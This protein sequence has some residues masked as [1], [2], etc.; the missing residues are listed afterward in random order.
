MTRAA[1]GV[2]VFLVMMA[3]CLFVP[4]GRIDW[5]RAWVFLLVMAAFSVVSLV[6]VDPDLLEER[7]SPGPGVKGWDTVVASLG[8]AGLYPGTAIVAGMEAAHFGAASPLGAASPVPWAIS[9]PAFLVFVAGYGF[10]LQ[11][12]RVNRFF[13]TF[14]RIQEDRGQTVI[15]TGPY[16]LVRHPG[17][18][19]VLVAHLVLPAALGSP[20]AFVPALLGAAFFVLRTALEDATLARELPGYAEYRRQVRYRLLPGVW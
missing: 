7:S 6:V 14:V 16:A 10:A 8:A 9:I 2:G 4:A 12:M 3:G 15:Q 5:P 13:A 17:Y 19:G 20:R 1:L 11:A 18:T